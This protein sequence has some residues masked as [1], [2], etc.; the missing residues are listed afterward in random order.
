AYF[1]DR[2]IEIAEGASLHSGTLAGGVLRRATPLT[3]ASLAWRALSRHARVTR[4]RRITGVA[5]ATDM[6]V[7]SADERPL[8][9]QVDGDDLGEV[10]EAR[11]S[12]LP[13]ALNVVS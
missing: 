8:P 10:G 6:I 5:D 13:A 7:T 4:N 11:F 12:V 1:L 2:P 3:G 9:V